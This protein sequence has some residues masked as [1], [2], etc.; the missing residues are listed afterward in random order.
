MEDLGKAIGGIRNLGCEALDSV[1]REGLVEWDMLVTKIAS[2]KV[3]RQWSPSGP[4]QD[5]I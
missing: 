3:D 1:S 5:Q 2:P 4:I